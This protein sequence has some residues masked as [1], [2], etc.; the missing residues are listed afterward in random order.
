MRVNVSTLRPS[1]QRGIIVSHVGM[2]LDRHWATSGI[3]G[4]DQELIH[5][6]LE[7]EEVPPG[8]GRWPPATPRPVVYREFIDRFMSDHF[9][10]PSDDASSTTR[11]R[12]F[13]SKASTWSAWPDAGRP[14]APLRHGRPTGRARSPTA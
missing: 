7:A 2:N 10:D 9:L 5:G 3:D 12:R 14:A 11:S 4:D 13:A 6:W 1:G 8:D